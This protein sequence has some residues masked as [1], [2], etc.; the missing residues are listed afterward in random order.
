MGRSYSDY[1]KVNKDYFCESLLK[2]S[3]N[4]YIKFISYCIMPDHYHLL[5]KIL[6]NKYLSKYISDVENSFT[7]YFN[8]KFKRKG[9]LWQT[10]FKSVKIESNEQLLHVSRYIHLNPTTS[11]LVDMPEEWQF[12]SYKEYIMKPKILG[13]IVKEIS[14]REPLI[15]KRFVENNQDYQR[16][17]KEIKK[18]IIE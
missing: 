2:Q 17:L 10:T 18:L 6:V 16:K 5:V 1:I 11:Y 13:N 12:S 15:Y 7:R 8:I 14:I 3:S 4:Q 9:P